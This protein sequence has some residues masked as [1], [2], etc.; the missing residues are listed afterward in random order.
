MKE[1]L[2]IHFIQLLTNEIMSKL[3]NNIKRL[4]GMVKNETNSGGN[5][6]ARI[7]GLF[8]E[9]A[10]ELEKKYDKTESDKQASEHNTDAEAHK[11]IQ[12]RIDTVLNDLK[13]DKLDKTGDG[14]DVSV[15]FDE[16]AERGNVSSGD[17]LSVLLGKVR[18]WFAGLQ[19]VAFSGKT[20]D[21]TDDAE[22][23]LTTDTEKARWNDTYTQEE[24]DNKD[25]EAL[26]IAKEY[27]NN[28]VANLGDDVYRKA[29]VYTK[30]EADAQHEGDLAAAKK[31][32][33][34]RISEL[35]N[36]SPAALDTL[37]EIANALNNDPHFA[38]TIMALINGKADT[39]HKHT[40]SQ[41]T[42]F[43]TSMP[44][45]DVYSWAKQ[46]NKPS[47]TPAEIGA[48]PAGHNHDAAYQPK[49]SYAAASH[50]HDTVY[51]PKGSYA[52]ASH[53]HDATYAAKTHTHTADQISDTTT[54]VMMTKAER[55]KLAGLEAGANK[56]IHP[57]NVNTRHVT[58]A[59]KTKWNNSS[60][61]VSKS[62]NGYIKI[63]GIIIQWGSVSYTLGQLSSNTI[64]F[65]I[66]F[67]ANCA[68]ITLSSTGRHINAVYE[69]TI[70]EKY[71]NRF[72]V[73][74]LHW[75][76]DALGETRTLFFQAIGY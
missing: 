67:P 3:I 75:G 54:K 24:T 50:N 40:K 60:P 31:F 9:I 64:Y 20:A 51:Q 57:D 1:F 55:S 35:I 12:E 28:Q 8:E 4:A 10:A 47:Y 11:N 45:S 26:R 7:G 2:T 16:A 52:A 32:A 25:A 63:G 69:Y 46:P 68:S 48:A 33:T 23:R 38:T 21:L 56:Y 5:T 14:S 17:T 74:E 6:A 58:D 61:V 53:N 41:I 15:V 59:E 70:L 13:Q 29:E 36:G 42:D 65:P 37:Y 34:D 19:A 49:G 73:M 72:K 27:A 22:H 18:K 62:S 44:A 66:S 43:P 76:D 39:G 30:Q 71:L